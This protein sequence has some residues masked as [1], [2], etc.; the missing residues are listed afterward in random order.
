M[1][2]DAAVVIRE[3]CPFCGLPFGSCQHPMNLGARIV[4]EPV[5]P[6]SPPPAPKLRMT[7]PAD[8]DGLQ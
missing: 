8:D 5:L 1:A 4:T 6:P 7:A 3:E 2:E